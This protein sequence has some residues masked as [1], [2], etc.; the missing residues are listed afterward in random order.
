MNK[1][2]LAILPLMMSAPARALTPLDSEGSAAMYNLLAKAGI[3]N[4]ATPTLR[5]EDILCL[6]GFDVEKQVWTNLCKMHDSISKLDVQGVSR[7][8]AQI[9][10]SLLVESGIVGHHLNGFFSTRA[11]SVECTRT[12]SADAGPAYACTMEE[13]MQPEVFPPR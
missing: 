6:F 10:S 13:S 7:N 3:Q 11:H 12:D 5:A 1:L 9:F 2:M 8:D 4:T